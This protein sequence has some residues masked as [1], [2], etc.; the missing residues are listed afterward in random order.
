[1]VGAWSQLKQNIP[2][3]YG[4]GTALEYMIEQGRLDEVK[5]LYGES[6]YFKTLI[7]NSM[8]SLSKTYFPLTSYMREDPEYGDLWNMMHDEYQKSV[9]YML[10]ISDQETLMETEVVNSLSV[11]YREQIVLP[12][13]AIQQYALQKIEET[14]DEELKRVYQKMVTRSLFGNINAS[15]NSA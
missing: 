7:Q 1:F 5:R 6:L 12:L 9:K 14:D 15:R 3:F 10:E 2:G 8:M 11:N 13:L 4:L